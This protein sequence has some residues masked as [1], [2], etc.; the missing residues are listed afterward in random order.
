MQSLYGTS[1]NPIKNKIGSSL[2]FYERL[3]MSLTRLQ[4]NQ[5]FTDILLDILF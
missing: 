4:I 5:I 1:Q 3:R 2:I